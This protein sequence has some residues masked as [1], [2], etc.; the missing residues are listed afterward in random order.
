MLMYRT[1]K[2]TATPMAKPVKSKTN[3]VRMLW[4]ASSMIESFQLVF[5]VLGGLLDV[6]TPFYIRHAR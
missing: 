4:S 1:A 6:A 3:S 2:M 5:N